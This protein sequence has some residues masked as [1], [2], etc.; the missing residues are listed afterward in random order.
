MADSRGRVR[1]VLYHLEASFGMVS[2]ARFDGMFLAST[3]ANHFEAAS[4]STV[5]VLLDSSQTFQILDRGIRPGTSADLRQWQRS[6]TSHVGYADYEDAIAD[7]EE[8]SALISNRLAVS[9]LDR[10][11]LV[12]FTCGDDAWR[13]L[14]L[15]AKFVADFSVIVWEQ[16]ENG[17]N[18]KFATL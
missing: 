5:D 17:T 15:R 9:T 18:D 3:T 8:V 6:G 10:D 7:A 4:G 1:P 2:G 12:T 13:R 16:Q 14:T 11:Q